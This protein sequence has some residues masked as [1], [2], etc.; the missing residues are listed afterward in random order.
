MKES[1]KKI[2]AILILYRIIYYLLPLLISGIALLTYE[3]KL[4]GRAAI[5]KKIKNRQK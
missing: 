3:F 1:I 4:A 2:F 5:I